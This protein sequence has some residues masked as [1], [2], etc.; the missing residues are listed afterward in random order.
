MLPNTLSSLSV[1]GV[2][3]TLPMGTYA[4]G[5]LGHETIGYIAMNFLSADTLSFVQDTINS[6]FDN[7]LGP[8][9]PWADTVR[10]ETAFKFSA[11]FH[12]I[13]AEDDPLG[14]SCSVD[15]DRDCGSSGCLLTA[16]ANYTQRVTDMS[17]DFTQRQEALMFIDHFLGDIGQ[18]LHVE[19]YEVGG[20]DIK[21]I[22]NGKS[23]NLHASWD[24]GMIETFLDANFDGSVTEW[25]ASLT[26]SIK[27]GNFSSDAAGWIS[28]SS[29]TQTL[30]RRSLSDEIRAVMEARDTAAALPE[31]A[32]PLGWAKESNAF[33]CTDV[34]D[35]TTGED[36]CTG[37]YFDNAIPIIELQ[38][39]KQGYRLAAWLN[40]IIDGKTNLP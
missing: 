21:A 8:A 9:A 31:L 35:F 22:C 40:V 36:L 17:L 24:T 32:C 13:D 25:A 7:S 2:A 1:F 29:I 12:F 16:I 39:A 15:E 10:Y 20:N 33:D 37:T 30:R 38:I 27:T 6:T 19:A 34:F 26:Q 18:P 11:P 23:T 28:C 4:W 14:G 5:A 3:L